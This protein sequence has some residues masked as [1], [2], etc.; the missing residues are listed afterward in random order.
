MTPADDIADDFE[1]APPDKLALHHRRQ[2][3]A[4][5]DGELSPDEA[6]FMLRRLEH[7]GELAACWERWQ[8]CG[9]VLRGRGHVLLPADFSRRVASAIERGDEAGAAPVASQPRSGIARWGGRAALAASV[10]AVA[11]FVA[12]Q[13]PGDGAP[14]AADAPA[15]LVATFPEPVL[16]PGDSPAAPEPVPVPSFEQAATALAATAA[17]SELPRRASERRSRGQSQRA[18]SRVQQ[19]I[20]EEQAPVMVA[21]SQST[22]AAPAIFLSP[23]ALAGSGGPDPFAAPAA[24]PPRPWPRAI[25]PALSTGGALSASHGNGSA[26]TAAFHPFEPRLQPGGAAPPARDDAEDG[27]VAPA[28]AEPAGEGV[29]AP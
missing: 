23:D 7:D 6:R 3:S 19:H 14:A 9:D 28:P 4:M 17:V 29:D 2:L 27:T 25:L 22:P 10:A 21:A 15:N 12:R 1:P 18:A 8:V 11:L 16:P 20:A 24:S 26:A 13:L 5:L